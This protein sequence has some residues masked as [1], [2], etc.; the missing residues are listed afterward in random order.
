MVEH[1]QMAFVAQP[2]PVLARVDL[3][4][5]FLNREALLRANVLFGE[6]DFGGVVY[7]AGVGYVAF[8][9]CII[10][11][12]RQSE[13]E[14]EFNRYHAYILTLFLCSKHNN[15]QLHGP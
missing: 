11:C 4:A 10:F 14:R 6:Y 1:N 2:I 8:S 5:L 9:L 13:K 15:S 12:Y 7:I 3:A